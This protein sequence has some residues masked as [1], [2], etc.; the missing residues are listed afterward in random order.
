D[1]R[2][3]AR[4][5]RGLRRGVRRAGMAPRAAARGRAGGPRADAAAAPGRRALPGCPA[6]RP[7]GERGVRARATPRR[8]G[9]GGG[10]CAARAA[11]RLVVCISTLEHVGF[12]NTVYG[13][14]AERDE[15][16]H[17]RA[18]QELRRVLARGGRLLVTVPCGER[19]DLEWQI[20][21]PPSEWIE[22]FERAGFLVFEDELYAVGTNGWRSVAEVGAARYG[23]RGPGA[24]A[25]LCA[26]LRPSR[27]GE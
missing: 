16:G 15:L 6:G 13:L 24:S 10:G 17:E 8:R 19:Q 3:L 27:L 26:E 12:D 18:L 4:R 9:R 7:R 22:L 14:E 25:V 5:G 21:R 20:Q 11:V 23:E 1:A 2:S